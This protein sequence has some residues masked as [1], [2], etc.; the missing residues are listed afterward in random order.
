MLIPPIVI[1]GNVILWKHDR[2]RSTGALYDEHFD[3]FFQP[4]LIGRVRWQKGHKPRKHCV[5]LG[6]L[7]L[8]TYGSATDRPRG[9]TCRPRP[10]LSTGTGCRTGTGLLSGAAAPA[11]E[12]AAGNVSAR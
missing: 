11:R 8:V 1:P 5:L 3:S 12:L 7:Q 9:P 10:G 6:R 4:H 2:R